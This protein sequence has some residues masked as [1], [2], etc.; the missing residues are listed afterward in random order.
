MQSCS[1]KNKQG[2]IFLYNLITIRFI[3]LQ[4]AKGR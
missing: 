2:E 4:G 3:F 1:R